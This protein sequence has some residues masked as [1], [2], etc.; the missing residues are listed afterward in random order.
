MN[1]EGCLMVADKDCNR[2]LSDKSD[3]S[4]ESVPLHR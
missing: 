3:E 4:L 1:V 2:T